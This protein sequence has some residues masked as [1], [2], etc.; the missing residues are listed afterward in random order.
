MN[1]CILGIKWIDKRV[2]AALSTIDDDSMVEIQRRT[3]ACS[4]G[5]ETIHKSAIIQNYNTYMGGV[6]KAD[7]WYCTM[8]FLTFPRNGG[9]E[10]FSTC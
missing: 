5:I 8:D 7:S 1:G 6:D 3:S 9:N 10:Y 2:V 4:D